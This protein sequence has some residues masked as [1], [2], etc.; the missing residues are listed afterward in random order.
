LNQ[1]PTGPL[2]NSTNPARMDELV[3]TFADR[4]ALM[5]REREERRRLGL[6]EQTAVHNSPEVRIRAWE[7][8]HGLR[9]PSDPKH[10]V[11]AVIATETGLTEGQVRE[12]QQ[13]RAL[14]AT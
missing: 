1:R 10:P 12:E 9:M 3:S 4:A 6:A 7:R 5:A 14:A 11:L 2:Q 13:A 8:I